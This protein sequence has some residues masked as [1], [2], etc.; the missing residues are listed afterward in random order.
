MPITLTN[1][2]ATIST[3]EYF[4]ASD[5]TTASYQTTDLVLQAFIHFAAMAAGDSFEIKVYENVNGQGP[6]LVWYALVEGAQAN[7]VVTPSLIVGEGWEIS[8]KKLAGTNRVVHWSLR[9]VE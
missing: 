6:L 8:V 3:T 1:D 2:S 9:K 4:L 7:P 5:S